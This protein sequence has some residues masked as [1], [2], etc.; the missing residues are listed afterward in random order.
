[1][2]QNSASRLEVISAA[3]LV[4]LEWLH[5]QKFADAQTSVMAAAMR[6]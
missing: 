1:M 6:E 3:D 4:P 5:E 2:R